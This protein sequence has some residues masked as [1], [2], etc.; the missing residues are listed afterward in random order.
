LEVTES[1]M[2]HDEESTSEAL[3]LLYRL[4]ARI[5]LDDFGTRWVAG[6][7]RQAGCG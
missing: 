7:M 4:G 5:A 3:D 2:I 1:F 6:T